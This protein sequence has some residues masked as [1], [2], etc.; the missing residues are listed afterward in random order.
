MLRKAMG[1]ARQL[2]GELPKNVIYPLVV[3]VVG[4]VTAG[5]I[6]L[7]IG[8]SGGSD[9]H[10]PEQ[11]TFD[12]TIDLNVTER[13]GAPI[14]SSVGN[15]ARTVGR[16][17]DGREVRFVG[18]C[19]GK[20][21]RSVSTGLP[22][23]RWFVLSSRAMMSAAD[24]DGNPPVTLKPTGCVGDRALPQVSELGA[25]LQRGRLILRVQAPGATVVG[26]AALR[27]GDKQWRGLGLVVGRN[28]FSEAAGLAG[29]MAVL[30]VVCWDEGVPAYAAE[31]ENYIE[32]LGSLGRASPSLRT[33]AS[34]T[35]WRGRKAACARPMMTR[36]EHPQKQPKSKHSRT[37]QPSTVST[38]PATSVEVR[39]ISPPTNTSPAPNQREPSKTSPESENNAVPAP[40][41]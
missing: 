37:P 24:V 32:E 19:I 29:A 22:D 35:V 9:G 21:E 39:T 34:K 14:Y 4:G 28:V 30:A 1:V 12:G 10:L 33:V 3:A 23:E 8:S 40:A 7:G 25:R 11:R 5:V 27:P 16:V 15:A 18:F 41:E 13:G 2:A 17:R 36:H 26:F 31:F 38:A 6:L 20:A